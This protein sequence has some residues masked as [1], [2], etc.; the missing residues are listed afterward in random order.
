MF[1]PNAYPRLQGEGEKS[2]LQGLQSSFE[3][4]G[5]NVEERF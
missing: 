1:A 4:H 2:G 3:N 5:A